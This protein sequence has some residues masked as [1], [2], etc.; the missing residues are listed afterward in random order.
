MDARG[1]SA[2][3][4]ARGRARGRAAPRP[5]EA[6]ELAVRPGSGGPL[7]AE[8]QYNGGRSGA[9]DGVSSLSSRMQSVSIDP[10]RSETP[11]PPIRIPESG[12]E[13][14]AEKVEIIANSFL[15][16]RRPAFAL[17]QYHVDF[18]PCVPS[19]EMRNMM[20]AEQVGTI[21]QVFEFDGMGLLF[22]PVQL[23]DPI[24][25]LSS[26][27]KTDKREI[28][29]RLKFVAEV[30]NDDLS[31]QLQLYNVIFKRI[32]KFSELKCVGRNYYSPA[33]AVPIP[34]HKL[35]VWPGFISSIL[36]CKKS[37]M[38]IMD[39]S[40]KILH[41]GTVLQLMYDMLKECRHNVTVFQE[42]CSKKLIGQIVLTRYNNKTYR[43]DSINWNGTPKSP[44]TR[45]D[46][47][48]ELFMDYFQRAYGIRLTDMDQPL[49]CSNPKSKGRGGSGEDLLILL[50]ELCYLTGL[51][52]EVR[53]DYSIMRDIAT[54]TRVEPATRVR[55]LESFISKLNRNPEAKNHAEAW[56]LE[57]A[58][59]LHTLIGKRC[60][61][62]QVYQGTEELFYNA[63]NADWSREM[64]NKRFTAPISLDKWVVIV[65]DRDKKLAGELV[66]MLGRICPPTGV[67]VRECEAVVLPDD[68]NASY[69]KALREK[70]NSS[71]QI[72]VCIVPSNRADRYNAIK[73]FCC[74]ENPVPSQVVVAR[75]LMKS[76]M[77][78]SVASKIAIQMNC[79][80][81]GEVW[82]LQV[83][84]SGLMVVGIDCYHDSSKKGRSVGAFVASF[85]K[86]LT[87]YYS[88]CVPQ[89]EQQEIVDTLNVFMS[90]AIKHF[91]KVNGSYP[92]TIIAYRDG[93]GDGQ[94]QVVSKYEVKQILESFKTIE[95]GYCPKFSFIIVKK[96]INSRF[97]AR[98]DRGITNPPPGTVID[99]D[100]THPKWYDFFLIS[101]SVRQGTV[102]PTNYNVI[103]DNSNLKAI[104]QQR[105]AYKLTHLYYNWPGTIRV[106][107]P[108][109]YAHKLAFL[110]GQTLHR[111]ADQKLYDHLYYL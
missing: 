13:D 29:I 103:Y 101:Q 75:T 99:A 26:I 68:S 23:R 59:K 71:V 39:V 63:A 82:N 48:E 12:P 41:T 107:A 38:L 43:I 40:H 66:D 87:R 16:R 83:P 5:G 111:E 109:Q 52:D 70:V 77:L 53:T 73:T 7:P 1:D 9:S 15:L 74:I 45:S 44:F 55:T 61:K 79:K 62:E 88:R 17:Y 20:M 85:N 97:F 78:S 37:P 93:V 58:D 35:E 4:R 24:T 10:V 31:T 91:K 106:P 19:K 98:T 56:N 42:M 96:R 34:Q 92:G 94:V 64:K 50:P 95:P 51:M 11:L 46:G 36:D 102:S 49:L 105:L 81:G 21:G 30:G 65:N 32:L 67:N 80:L 57:F 69:L 22:I 72:V 6:D 47:T 14:G 90:D 2:M 84:I 100:V 18:E 54:H 89:A 33:E 60:K 108:C 76:N 25:E 27:R 8:N 104:Q 28:A 110:V 86:G 3:G